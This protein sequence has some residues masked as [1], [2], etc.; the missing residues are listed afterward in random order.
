MTNQDI[1]ARVNA[2]MS[3][4]FEIP[5]DQLKPEATLFDDLGLDSLD[6]VDMLV[7]LEDNVGIRVDSE[8]LKTVRTMQDIYN[9]VGNLV[10]KSE[11]TH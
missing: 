3:E 7:S 10:A 4:G 6:A 9:L 1:I 11:A 5:A 2:I 8:Q